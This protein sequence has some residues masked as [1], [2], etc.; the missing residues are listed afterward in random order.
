MQICSK[1]HLDDFPF[2]Y[3]V[4]KDKNHEDH[5]LKYV[6]TSAGGL[7][8]INIICVT[9]SSKNTVKRNMSGALSPE[10]F[11]PEIAQVIPHGLISILKI[12][13]VINIGVQKSS[14]IFY[15]LLFIILFF[16]PLMISCQIG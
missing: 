11:S 10:N 3:W 7:R 12:V 13:I 14:L 6:E 2:H 5:K 8:G 1:G 16:L 9:C 15:F 4:H